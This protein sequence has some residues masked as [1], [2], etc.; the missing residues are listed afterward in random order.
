MP[1]KAAVTVNHSRGA[2]MRNEL[3]EHH[4]PPLSTRMVFLHHLV[5]MHDQASPHTP[6]GGETARATPLTARIVLVALL[7]IAAIV[8]GVLH[9]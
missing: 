1:L 4:L 9:A 7:L 2:A 8:F 5:R 3:S 6:H